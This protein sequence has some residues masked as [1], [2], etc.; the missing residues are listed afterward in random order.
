MNKISLTLIYTIVFCA[1]SVACS[2]QEEPLQSKS[3]QQASSIVDS[4]MERQTQA[5]KVV[6]AYSMEEWGSD[7]L[8]RIRSS[9]GEEV[10]SEVKRRVQDRLG[11]K[12]LMEKRISLLTETYTALE[13]NRLSEIY[14]TSEGKA[15]MRKTPIYYDRL[16]E[17]TE[18]LVMTILSN[19]N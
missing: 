5:I 8:A 6:S 19:S 4:P 15:I 7:L 3:K 12:E 14:S 18:P 17:L 10:S 2:K 13:L 11:A 16:R 9:V 1:F